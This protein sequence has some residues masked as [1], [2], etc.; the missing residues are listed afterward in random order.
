MLTALG[1]KVLYWPRLFSGR[2]HDGLK[3]YDSTYGYG[4]VNNGGDLSRSLTREYRIRGNG[5]GPGHS[6][7][8]RGGGDGC[9]DL[10][11]LD[12]GGAV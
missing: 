5:Y 11:D 6:G 2:I 4:G 9:G 7:D 12:G 3:E 8:R 1:K 10:G